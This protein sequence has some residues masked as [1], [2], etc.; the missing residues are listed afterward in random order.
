[1]YSRRTAL[2]TGASRKL[3]LMKTIPDRRAIGPIGQNATLTPPSVWL[4]A[5]PWRASAWRST[6][7]SR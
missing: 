3:R 6:I 1:M 7:G 5:K 4:G 2:C